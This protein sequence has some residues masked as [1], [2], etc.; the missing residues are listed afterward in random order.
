MTAHKR[1]IRAILTY[2]VILLVAGVFLINEYLFIWAALSAAGLI[3]LLAWYKKIS[4]HKMLTLF[5]GLNVF[6]DAFAVAIWAGFPATQWSI[7]QL[8]FTVVGAE[9]AIA[10]ALF[11]F[12]LFGLLKNRR[13]APFLAIALTV[14][15][16]SFATYV[17]FPSTA[18]F[19]TLIWSI[20][21]V[22]F[23]YGEIKS[24]SKPLVF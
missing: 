14:T 17:F 21:I 1:I 6:L 10:A 18:I 16:R 2:L 4:H 8:G 5:V 7:Y 13:W 24:C 11:A 22:Y 19:V 20:L 9:A 15:Q 3:I 23:A 12:T